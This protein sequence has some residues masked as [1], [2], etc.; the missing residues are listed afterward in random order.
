MQ[1]ST[2]KEVRTT[3]DT[4]NVFGGYNHNIA[5]ADGEL[6]D[7]KNM[8]STN[9]PV[10]SPRQKRSTYKT[11]RANG[12]IAKDKL[13]YVDGTSLYVG[14]DRVNGLTLSDTTKQ[15]VS[16]GAYIVIFPDKAYVNTQDITDYGYLEVHNTTSGTV[17]YSMCNIDG[18]AYSDPTIDTK[19]P[20]K[21]N[22][23]DL[24][25][26]TSKKPNALMQ[27]S[28]VQQMWVSIA[29]SYVKIACNGIADGLN[30]QDAVKISGIKSSLTQ[31]ASLEGQ[32]SILWKVHK[33]SGT[34]YI[35]V[36]GIINTVSTQTTPLT[37]ERTLPLMDYVTESNNRLWGCR[38][39]LNKDGEQV[40]EIYSSKLG[41]FRNWN[42]FSGT[43]ADSYV[44]SCGTDGAF[45]GAIS[46]LGYPL[47]FK[48]NCIHKVFGNYPSNYQIK[49]TSCYG[50]M[51]GASNSLTICNDILMYK[52]RDGIC[53]YDGS[54]PSIVSTALGDIKYSDAYAGY[55]GNKY[56]ISML[57]D[58]DN[59]WHLF[60]FDTQ[61]KMWHKE[62][63]LRVDMFCSYNG[64]L[65]YIDH[66]TKHIRTI[67]GTVGDIDE[68]DVEW[69]AT[70]SIIGLKRTEGRYTVA[71]PNKK[72]IGQML[73]RMSMD[74][75][76]EANFFI[77]YDSQGEWTNIAHLIGTSLRSFFVP[78]RPR[79]C[80]HF[81]I[82]IEGTGN[83]NIY[84]Y[85]KIVEQGSDY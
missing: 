66:D 58:S 12:I 5:I 56:Y 67:L 84:S 81:R 83:V 6:Y 27:W 74:V 71:S 10:L 30:T 36:Q 64:E 25:I 50:V 78:I 32:T 15:I 17:T 62:D 33:G 20:E 35:V 73:V 41:D 59:T 24:W 34:D 37:V 16:M 29:T 39:G 21:P 69:N 82:R 4:V 8:S 13:C 40:N 42:Y 45:T 75:G 43:S 53:V 49:P 3:K 77:Q 85:T 1:F 52:S 54:L 38:Y 14:N 26:D 22:N 18:D 11:C 9:Y 47:F 48:E 80:D 51:K 72:Y 70:T 19:P 44:A 63:N 60:A 57:M 76:A 79:R 46:F 55:V 61:K 23:M 65:Y 7:M 28:E 68:E 2:L 31:L